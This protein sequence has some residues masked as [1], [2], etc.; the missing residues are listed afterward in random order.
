MSI[1][2]PNVNVVFDC[3]NGRLLEMKKSKLSVHS[4]KPTY[5]LSF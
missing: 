1:Q 4:S 5:S 3:L 2:S